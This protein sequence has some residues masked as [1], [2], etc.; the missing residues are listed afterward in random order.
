MIKYTL[1][2]SILLLLI[3]CTKKP[4][5]LFTILQAK[6]SEIYFNNTLKD[7]L[8]QT[9]LDYLY[10][11]N[12]GGVAIG[13]INNDNLPDIYFTSNQQQNKLYLNKGNLKFED[14]TAKANVDSSSDWN[15]GVAMADVNG[16]G[17]LDIYV[18]AVTGTNGFVGQNELFINNGDLTFTEQAHAY[19]L[20]IDNYSSSV[21]F[22]DYDL[23][24]DLDMYLLNHAIHT[25]ESFG[26]ASIRNKRNYQSGDKLFRN[27]NNKFID[28]SESAGIYGSASG[29]GLGLAISDFN[30]DG[31][32]DIYVSND[33]HEDDYYYL[34]NGDGTFTESLKV[35][36]GHTSKFSM[37]NDAADINNDGFTDLITLDMLPEEEKVLKSSVGDGNIQIQNLRTKQYGYHHQYA[38]N[39][40]QI[41]QAASHFTETAFLS[42]IAATDW[43]WSALIADYN[44]DTK[45]DVFIANGIPKR[46]ND[47][48]YIKYISNDQ[49]KKKIETTNL[50]DKEALNYM[51]D[52][53][54]KN[55][56][57]QGNED[58]KFENTTDK[59]V[60]QNATYSNG[61]AYADLDN[62]G[63]L[64]VVTNNINAPASIY[65]NNTNA[66]KNY[67]QLKF[68]YLQ[69]NYF[70]IG[71]KVFLY[72]N[73]NIQ[74][75]ELFTQRGFQSSCQPLLHFG[76]DTLQKIDSIKVIWP[77]KTFQILKDVPVNQTL[78]V[79][80]NPKEKEFNYTFLHSKKDSIFYKTKDNLGIQYTHSENNYIDSNRHKL[81]PYQISDRGPAIAV[82]DLNNDGKEDVF[83]GNGKHK[84]SEIYLQ[85]ESGFI[86]LEDS[87][88]KNKAIIEE[89]SAT[90]ADFDNDNKNELFI[91]SGGGEFFGKS[92][93]LQN[94]LFKIT[95]D[96]I[97]EFEMP[98]GYEDTAIV[99]HFD[100][101]LDGDQ[102][103][104]IGNATMPNDFGNIPE[105]YILENKKGVFVKRTLGN[106]GMIRDVSVTDF[107][108]DKKPDL[109]LV[110]EWMSP[111]FLQNNNGDFV[112]VSEKYLS[113]PLNGLWRAIIPFDI[114][115]DGDLD[116]LLGNWGTNTKFTATQEYPLLMYYSD[117]D[118]NGK[119]ET[120]IA[121][122]K[123]EKYYPI[124]DLD[125]LSA[126]LISLT[127]KKFTTYKSFAGLPINNVFDDTILSKAKVF[128]VHTLASGILKNEN[129]KFVFEAFQ[130]QLQVAPINCFTKINIGGN[131]TVLCAGN[132]FGIK[133]YHGRFDSFSGALILDQ[134]NI[135]LG[136]A[137]GLDFF[138]K[139]V[140]KLRTITVNNNIYLIALINND[141]VQI[142]QVK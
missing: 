138:N 60:E 133:P 68:N 110:G 82:G 58:L 101:D 99:K 102:D 97:K 132:Y 114:D 105:S 7:T 123:K 79:S 29:Y 112:D 25:E 86:K 135:K 81:I 51:P 129:G 91:G 10:Y 122:E 59:W 14:I 70:G 31:Y 78:T 35:H 54:L 15:T 141:N 20:D 56:F 85:S 103:V 47:L 126:Q 9:I 111:L 18:C 98:E 115:K 90:I 2:I 46:P 32:P 128:K 96:G 66:T 53:K 93:A 22:F 120:I 11:Y 73:K 125:E 88:F 69:K 65:I 8:G 108:S 139:A 40:V 95:S 72:Q 136:N 119:T 21:S 55:I 33:F 121:V 43:S 109:I 52:G 87:I 130:N 76:L 12:G 39:M 71:T 19:G 26:K 94:N 63:D 113:K 89:G 64:D 49:V 24:G 57:F 34:N 44:Q 62:D 41:N 16:D 131:E 124:E 67:I 28:V 84:K 1:H 36:F 134:N 117:F 106:I 42:T 30:N 17:L 92:A 83:F 116:Y 6:D 127:K 118:N 48:D 27:D 75:K 74:Y 37:G 13:D 50:I 77:N 104:F 142:Y 107:N 38:R 4:D 3:G 140:S 80:V 5:K 23:D 61:S 137:I 45:Q 100:F